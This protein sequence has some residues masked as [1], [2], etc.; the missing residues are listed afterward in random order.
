M[1]R[2]R[3]LGILAHGVRYWNERARPLGVGRADFTGA[4]FVRA[5]LD[6]ID[7]RGVD[8]SGADLRHA[9]L[10]RADLRDA[11]LDGADL[12]DALLDEA[13]VASASIKNAKLHRTRAVSATFERAE[14]ADSDLSDADFTAAKVS[15][16]IFLRSD[17]TRTKFVAADLTG[18]VFYHGLMIE[19]Q[20]YNA[21]LQGA[22]FGGMSINDVEL[23]DVQGLNEIHHRAA[24][25]VSLDTLRRN[26]TVP[27]LK[28]FKACGLNDVEIA[29]AGLWRTDLSPNDLTDIAYTLARLR[30]TRP[31]MLNPLFISY[32][33]ADRKFVDRVEL[34][35]RE[36]GIQCWRDVKDMTVGPLDTQ[37]DRAIRLNP[38]VLLVL[39]A[40]SVRS[41][42]VAW[43]AATARRIE[44]EVG[45]R[46]LC[47]VT[48]DDAW[49]NC[50]W[51]G[52][53]RQQ[54][55]SYHLL[56]FSSWADEKGFRAQFTR[57]REGLRLYYNDSRH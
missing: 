45:R 23:S 16:A 5:R 37:I 36:H 51:P 1:A 25:F 46:I 20:L 40:A 48:L 29:F 14:F 12:S 57:L 27:V 54:I 13:I 38:T 3:D 52:P 26:P 7:L 11:I 24:S 49:T 8:F 17:L 44:R 47:P 28:F 2:Q 4:S 39:S 33:H 15:G 32:A 53:L 41:D 19:T 9:R 55:E 43:E 35:F 42:W 18:A 56:D 31:I 30:Q 6:E 10:R 21:Q 22:Y 34:E 50:D